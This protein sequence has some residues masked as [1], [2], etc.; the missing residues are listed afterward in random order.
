MRPVTDADRAAVDARVG[1]AHHWR[2]VQRGTTALLCGKG[3]AVVGIMLNGD[4]AVDN[5]KF[6]RLLDGWD[7]VAA[8]VAEDCGEEPTKNKDGQTES[9]TD[10]EN[11]SQSNNIK[12]ADTSQ[13][14]Q[15]KSENVQSSSRYHHLQVSL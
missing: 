8:K 3:F 12:L 10:Q 14:N 4:A 11:K 15:K 1:R 7:K 5:V 6:Q 13:E 2:A 9:M